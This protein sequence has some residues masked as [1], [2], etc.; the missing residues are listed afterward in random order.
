VPFYSIGGS[1]ICQ[2]EHVTAF[3]P[4][5]NISVLPEI[6]GCDHQVLRR[7]HFDVPVIPHI[8]L[9]AAGGKPFHD[10]GIIRDPF[11]V[12]GVFHH[13]VIG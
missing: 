10:H 13:F 7:R 9:D 8:Q 2:A 5:D 6:G 3:L 12:C 4:P 1:T 11:A